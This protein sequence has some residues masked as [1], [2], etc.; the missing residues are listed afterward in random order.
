MVGDQGGRLGL[1]GGL[2][3]GGGSGRRVAVVSRDHGS[4]VAGGGWDRL[5]I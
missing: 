3:H 4:G 1:D 2:L 5:G